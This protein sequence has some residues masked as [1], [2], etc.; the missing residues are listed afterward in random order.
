[1]SDVDVLER[2]IIAQKEQYEKALF[3][4]KNGRKETHWIWYIF[5]TIKN[6][7]ADTDFNIK[8]AIS[9]LDEAILYYNH[10]ILGNRLIEITTE[11][12]KLNDKTIENIF[13]KPDIKK[14]KSCMTLFNMV[15]NSNPV[16]LSILNK[17]FN[18]E[19]DDL[20]IEILKLNKI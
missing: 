6:R 20:T 5:P 17:Y 18:S 2:F 1:M 3:E 13:P 8:Y 9:N 14:V 19:N 15:P 12:Y 7:F 11:L 10:P 4:I 16:F